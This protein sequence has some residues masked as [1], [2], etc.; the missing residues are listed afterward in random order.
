MGSLL[1]AKIRKDPRF[2]YEFLNRRSHADYVREISDLIMDRYS[3]KYYLFNDKA[4]EIVRRV[5]ID[6]S[7][8]PIKTIKAVTKD[9]GY[10]RYINGVWE[11]GYYSHNPL[12][13]AE[14]FTRLFDRLEIN[15]NSGRLSVD[16]SL[17]G[18]YLDHKHKFGNYPKGSIACC[19]NCGKK[20]THKNVQYRPLCD[21]W[22]DITKKEYVKSNGNLKGFYK[23][24]FKNRT[25]NHAVL[26][27]SCWNK[28]RV[29]VKAQYEAEEIDRVAILGYD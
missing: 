14:H 13:V 24:K 12:M 18:A 4:K 1:R 6:I 27:M 11:I 29:I 23:E 28:I 26:C 16:D 7:S 3:R 21:G 9:I 22:S 19:D 20:D 5:A 8:D 2:K 15:V 17:V 10:G 25:K